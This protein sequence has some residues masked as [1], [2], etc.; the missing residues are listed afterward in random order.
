[1]STLIESSP[2]DNQVPDSDAIMERVGNAYKQICQ[3]LEKSIIGQEE[4]IEQ[5]II[6]LFSRGHCLLT[7][8]PGLGK[9]RLVKSIADIF[10]LSFKRIQSTPDLMPA[11]I[12]GTDI[13]EEDPQSGKHQFKFIKGPIFTNILLVDEI[14]RTPPKTQS[15]LLEAMEERQ[16]TAG[17]TTYPLDRP[18]FVLATQNPIELE[19]TYS[20][21]EAQLDRF[22][23]NVI[24]SY[25][26]QEDEEKMVLQTTN[27]EQIQLETLFAAEEIQQ[28]QALV[29]EVPVSSNVLSYAVRL[30]CATRAIPKSPAYIREMVKWG[31]GSRASQALVLA[32][33]ARALLQGRYNVACEDI[34]ALAP[35]VLRHRVLPNFHAD[36][37]GVR[38]DDL[39]QRLL[40]DIPE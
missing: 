31:A 40:K 26:S 22:I 15:A 13:L 24:L 9:T 20:L 29:R 37:E 19:G 3:E 2:R 1:M 4:I 33:K 10:S 12:Y 18:F 34:Q 35:S 8:V 11:D 36:A 5:I 30:V 6:A 23:F 14:N 25:L 39:I 16:V 17:G 32:G 27:P 28:I 21:P 7:G 38:S